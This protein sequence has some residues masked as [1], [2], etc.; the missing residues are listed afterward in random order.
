M[1]FDRYSEMCTKKGVT[2]HKAAI[3]NGLSSATPTQWKKK[4]ITPSTSVLEKL[5]S[6]F[7]CTVDYLLEKEPSEGQK[8]CPPADSREAE[9][10]EFT[11]R[12]QSLPE[13]QRKVVM[14][15]M[16]SYEGK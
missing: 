8:E 12:F 6:Y 5:A 7:G 13:N 4:G 1:F 3:E 9:D 11:Q 15:L 2:P 14:D 16:K 10:M